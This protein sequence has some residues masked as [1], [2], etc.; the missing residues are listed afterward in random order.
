MFRC[1]AFISFG[2]FANPFPWEYVPPTADRPSERECECLSACSVHSLLKLCATHV[3]DVCGLP[4]KNERTSRTH[5]RKVCT[6]CIRFQSAWSRRKKYIEILLFFAQFCLSLSRL[7][8]CWHTERGWLIFARFSAGEYAQF[9]AIIFILSLFLFFFGRYCRS[10]RTMHHSLASLW[11]QTVQGA[12]F[13][14]RSSNK[15]K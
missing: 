7:A 15:N 2:I 11:L 3:R 5:M 1:D 13:G 4:L 14:W 8:L 12:W 6:G 9:M 10:V